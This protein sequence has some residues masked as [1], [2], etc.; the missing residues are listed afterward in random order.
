MACKNICEVNVCCTD[1]DQ[2]GKID[3]NQ[4]KIQF[5]LKIRFLFLILKYRD[6]YQ[7]CISQDL[8]F[9]LQGCL[10]LTDKIVVCSITCII[11]VNL[12][13]VVEICS[14]LTCQCCKCIFCGKQLFQGFTAEFYHENTLHDSIV[15]S[16]QI[17]KTFYLLLS[18]CLQ[19]YLNCVADQLM[20]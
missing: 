18:L 6:F 1:F 7:P 5:K 2:T 20:N 10:C 16:Q 12:H 19:H 11:R 4:S 8:C 9:T 17:L 13:T 3:L 15:N 14:S